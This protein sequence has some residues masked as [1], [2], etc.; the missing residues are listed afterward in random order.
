MSYRLFVVARY[1][2]GFLL[3]LA[4]PAAA[5]DH[6]H[7]C[8]S[9]DGLFEVSDGS[10]YEVADKARKPIP[11]QVVS[12]TVL[13]SRK[14]YCLAKGNKYAFEGRSY[15][16]TI[17]FR[18]NAAPAEIRVLCELASDG[19]PAAYT[20]EKEVVTAET[21]AAPPKP[22]VGP[23]APPAAQVDWFHNGSLVRLEAAGAERRFVYV[24]PRKGMSEAGARS[25]DPVFVGRREGKRYSGTAYVYSRACGRTGYPV[26]GAIGDDERSVTLEGDVPLLG[27]GCQPRA[28]R[29]DVLVFRLS[30]V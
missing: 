27:P 20:C 26:S 25:G 2:A 11:Y 16:Q 4:V 29:R 7:E 21:K 13:A 14:G 10:L 9:P 24:R 6:F 5:S 23:A 30:G 19:L 12:E 15:V 17:R 18:M 22:S 28:H 1:V 3:T 8:R